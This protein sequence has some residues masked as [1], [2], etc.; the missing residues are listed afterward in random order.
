MTDHPQQSQKASWTSALGPLRQPL[1]RA[2]WIA[3]VVS[4]IGTWM[5]E[6]GEGWLMTTL[7]TSPILVGLLETAVALPMFLLALPAGA[8]ADILDRRRILIFTQGWMMV[9]AAV[10]GVLTLTGGVTPGLL[11]LLSFLLS[12]G[13][14]V[15]GPAWQASIP[16]LVSPSELPSAITLGSVGFNVARA[17]G[18]AIGGF[19]IAASGPWAAFILN[20]LSFVGVILVLLRWRREHH[21]SILPAERIAGAMRAGLRYVRYSPPLQAVL[22][23]T[24]AFMIFASAMWATLPFIARHEM[25]LSPLQFGMLI[26]SFGTGAVIGAAILAY[27][28]QRVPVNN[29]VEAATVLFAGLL[30]T[31]GFVRIFLP[32]AIAMF[33]GGIAWMAMMSSL[34]TAALT[35]SPSWVRA[36]SMSVYLLV[37]MGSF[38]AGGGLWGFAGS[39]VGMSFTL[40][41]AAVGLIA[42]LA[43]TLRYRLATGR[44]EDLT[45]SLHWPEPVI[46]FEPH[47][48]RGPVMV[49]IEYRI[50]DKNAREFSE[51]IHA[52]G[53]VRRRDG[54]VQWGVFKDVADPE[55]HVE[56]FI[57]ESWAEH[58]RQHD[59][60]TVA[61]RAMEDRIYSFHTGPDR[62]KVSHYIY[63]D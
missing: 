43:L 10:L 34:N 40:A 46:A 49:T 47:P 7:T 45:P 62:P 23:R 36:R 30:T 39:R 29:Q 20:A 32:V 31:L 19:V 35:A 16:D 8:L 22:I 11:L 63:S 54:A 2:L 61:D 44:G 17:I 4:N 56:T 12:V 1:F 59:R 14:A 24:A 3:S 58:M 53:K 50:Q 51:A 28:R 26:G 21:E 42:G 60:V 15:N 9:S 55:R 57:V 18:P 48:D 13:A 37:F 27:L 52:L 33:I 5:Q 38:A 25:G 41:I 6:V